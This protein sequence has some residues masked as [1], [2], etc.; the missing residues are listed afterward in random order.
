MPLSIS[1]NTGVMAIGFSGTLHSLSS[2]LCCLII[3]KYCPYYY[4][5]YNVH[6]TQV[7]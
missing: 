5:S 2:F 4:Y 1:Y 6:C 3:S 7:Q